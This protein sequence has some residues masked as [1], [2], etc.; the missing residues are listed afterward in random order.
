MR[1]VLFSIALVIIIFLILQ[2]CGPSS[3]LAKSRKIIDAV[4]ATP[5]LGYLAGKFRVEIGSVRR[6]ASRTYNCRSGNH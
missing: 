1:K 5:P 4:V 3:D 2:A 6:G